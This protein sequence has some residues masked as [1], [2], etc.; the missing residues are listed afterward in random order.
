M[1]HKSYRADDRSYYALIKKDIHKQ[2]TDAG[3]DKT[4]VDAIDLVVS[5]MTSNL[6]KYAQGG[7]LL[8]GLGTENDRK[9]IEIISL[10]DGPGIA[11]LS[12]VLTDGYSSTNTLGH[13]LGSIKRF[14]DNFD[15]YSIRQWGTVVVSRIYNESKPRAKR[16]IIELRGINVAKPG[17]EVSGDG[18][19]YVESKGGVRIM[20]ADG[21][22]HGND[23]H[24]AVEEACK[25][26]LNDGEK[27]PSDTI[28]LMHTAIRK[29]RGIVGGFFF[30]NFAEKEWTIAGVGNIA[31]K[32]LGNGNSK[33]FTAYN[34]IIGL[35]IPGTI[36]NVSVRQDEFSLFIACSDGIKSRWDLTKFPV[37]QRYD[38]TIIAAAIY[39]E[40]GRKSDDMSVLVCKTF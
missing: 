31:A 2:A 37:I 28:R 39:K 38:A 10:D 8:V 3:F 11:D 34:G 19:C 12:K 17:E 6:G 25:T 30:L 13:G 9:Y 36:N 21:L 1:Q 22:G 24:L 20:V 40:F 15:I 23:A 4:K 5:E 32:W 14:S 16:K 33:S 18:F 27:Q 7:E 26:F 35:N 29:T